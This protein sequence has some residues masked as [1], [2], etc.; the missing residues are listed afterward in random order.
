MWRPRTAGT[1]GQHGNGRLRASLASGTV[2]KYH[3]E[4]VRYG[5]KNPHPSDEDPTIPDV[6]V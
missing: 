3:C 1:A 6:S 2:R 5:L 4:T